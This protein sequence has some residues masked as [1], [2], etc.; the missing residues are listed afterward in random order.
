MAADPLTEQGGRLSPSR[1]EAVAINPIRL[2]LEG[3]GMAEINL[4]RRYPRARRNIG[5]R[6]VAQSDDNIRIARE[7]GREY[8]DG[9]RDTGY[10]GYRYDG[11]WIPI[12]EDMID[13]FGLKPGDRG[14]VVAAGK[15]VLY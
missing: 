1:P 6:T 9:S 4:L 13:H 14:L 7:Y 5:M 15:G 3:T 8:F 10:G 2:G 12:A 11:R